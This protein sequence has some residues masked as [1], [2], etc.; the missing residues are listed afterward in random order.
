MTD[1]HAAL[2]DGA[3]E[4][5]TTDLPGEWATDGAWAVSV[6]TQPVHGGPVDERC[7]QVIVY[8]ASPRDVDVD[9]VRAAQR[10][11]TSLES[12]V[13]GALAR[14]GHPRSDLGGQ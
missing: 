9:T 7:H 13:R 8:E 10:T 14:A 6:R 2:E 5:V 11:A 1:G 4:R 3:F 12:A